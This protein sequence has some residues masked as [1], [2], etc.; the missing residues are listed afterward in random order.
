M[1]DTAS[2]ERSLMETPVFTQL[3]DQERSELLAM[4]EQTR[5]S[6]RKALFAAIDEALGHLPWLL[7]G[8]A[9]KL[10]LG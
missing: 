7:R 3:S 1:E 10:L 2:R 9:R 4:I 8:T 6:R 5:R